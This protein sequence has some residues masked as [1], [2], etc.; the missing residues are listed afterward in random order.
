MLYM[1]WFSRH[2][3]KTPFGVLPLYPYDLSI[4][5]DLSYFLLF[6]ENQNRTDYIGVI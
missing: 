4:P 2:A 6:H 5:E 1:S 3:K